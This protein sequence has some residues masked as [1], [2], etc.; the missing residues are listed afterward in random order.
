MTALIQQAALCPRPRAQMDD[1]FRLAFSRF[2][3]LVGALKET[4]MQIVQNVGARI[5]REGAN[6]GMVG[7]KRRSCLGSR[8]GLELN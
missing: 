3:L 6:G 2:R 8:F 1:I 4:G 7:G 5:W